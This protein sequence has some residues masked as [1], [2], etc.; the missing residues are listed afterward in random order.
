MLDEISSIRLR[1]LE[2][3]EEVSRARS[4]R[5]V[6]RR[7]GTTSGQISK[8]IQSLEKRIGT[9]LFKRSAMG[10]LL[11]SQGVEFRAIAKELLTNGEKIEGL[12]SGRRKSGL[13]KIVAVAGT[14]FLNTYFTTPV[15]CALQ[16]HQ[17]STIFR[18]LDVAPD[19]IVPVGLRG[20]FDIVVHFGQLSWPGTW[21]TSKLGKVRWTLVAKNDHALSTKVTLAQVLEYP[22]VVPTYWTSE[23]LVRGNDQFPVP[24]SKRKTGYETAT[25]DAAV[26]IVLGTNHLAFLPALL[27]R[28][29]LQ[30]KQL[31]EIKIDRFSSVEMELHLSLK[32]DVVSAHTYD[33]FT[34][35]MREAL[36]KVNR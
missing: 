12:I 5:E 1:D 26:P 6:A 24:L 10:V 11:T 25:A 7:L 30:S 3:F 17:P 23:G 29:F 16:G 18:F 28:P 27:V 34:E 36:K 35:K 14:S 8:T 32:S 2:I 20:G 19:Q 22:F 13:T 31:K 21:V 33:L 4:I 15:V 9:K